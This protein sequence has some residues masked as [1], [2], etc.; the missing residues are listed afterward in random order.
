M[1]LE[2]NVSTILYVEDDPASAEIVR[3]TLEQAGYSFFIAADG[4][5]GFG[6]VLNRSHVNVRCATS[7][8]SRVH[9]AG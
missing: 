9:P 1:I 3:A 8:D 4:A 2:G 6:V 5:E 7:A